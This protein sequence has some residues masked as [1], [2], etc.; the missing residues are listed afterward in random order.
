MTWPRQSEVQKFY[1]KVGENQTSINVPA[2]Y[3]MHYA[4]D[5]NPQI[6][7]I[8]CHEKVAASL[9]RI[10]TKTFEVYGPGLADIGLGLFGGCLCV[11][12]MRG[13]SSWSMH[14]WGIAID[15][16][17]DRNQLRWNKT[18]ARFAQKVYEP[19]FMIVEGEGWTSLGRSRDYDWMHV[20]AARP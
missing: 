6:R 12:K 14:S 2:G 18:R 10:L 17:P 5:G 13:G 4:W 9:E 11:R 1:G 20:Q 16:D 8:T 3:P 19:F 7:K 15:L